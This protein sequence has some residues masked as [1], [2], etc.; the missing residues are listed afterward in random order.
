[1]FMGVV[2]H[3]VGMAAAVIINLEISGLH[4]LAGTEYRLQIFFHN[5][6]PFQMI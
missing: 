2:F 3:M 1:M 6:T 5:H 4:I